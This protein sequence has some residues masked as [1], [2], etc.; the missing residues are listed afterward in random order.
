MRSSPTI[1][2]LFS[3]IWPQRAKALFPSADETSVALL[4]ISAGNELDE[5]VSGFDRD[6]SGSRALSI[7]K[8]ISIP[9]GFTPTRLRSSKQG[10][11]P[12]H[13]L[14]DRF[15]AKRKPKRPR[16]ASLR[17]AVSTS[18][19]A[20]FHLSICEATRN[21]KR[22]GQPAALGRFFEHGKIYS[23]SDKQRAACSRIIT[24]TP[25]PAPGSDLD[26]ITNLQVVSLAFYQAQQHRHSA[27]YDIS[28]QW[29]RT[30]AM[31][32]IDQVD[33]AFQSWTLIRD[34]KFAH[35]YLLSL[36]GNP[37]GT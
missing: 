31:A 9:K 27:D 25:P 15:D 5:L 32:I 30:E 29:T 4:S 13:E 21:W 12:G 11:I 22:V 26:C 16:Q 24:S 37:K 6:P 7:A 33:A 8:S 23:A 28:K 35:A 1:P 14:S 20:L 18:Y 2:P 36:L 17:R 3:R 19:Y 34:H 10:R